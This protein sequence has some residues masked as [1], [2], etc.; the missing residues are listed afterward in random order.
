MKVRIYLLTFHNELNTLLKRDVLF[1]FHLK[2]WN[3]ASIGIS[4]RSL[5]KGTQTSNWSNCTTK[6]NNCSMV[7]K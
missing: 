6:R 7:F 5:L 1:G 4:V 3:F 2:F